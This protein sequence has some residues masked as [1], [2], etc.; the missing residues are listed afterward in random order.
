MAPKKARFK[1]F[2]DVGYWHL[3][4]KRAIA[5]N[6]RYWTN[7]GQRLALGLDGS[8]ANAPTATL[9]VYCGNGFDTGFS[10]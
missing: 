2:R 3:A 5:L 4:D 8:A 7:N 9:A 6:G 10:P 1:G